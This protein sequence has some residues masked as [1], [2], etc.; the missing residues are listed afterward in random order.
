MHFYIRAYRAKV[1]PSTSNSDKNEILLTFSLIV[2]KRSSDE[3]EESDHQGKVLIFR[4][5]LLT[6]FH[7]KCMENSKENMHF[8]IRA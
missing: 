8:Y 1:N 4:Q 5:T 6:S 7:K 2:L 3:N